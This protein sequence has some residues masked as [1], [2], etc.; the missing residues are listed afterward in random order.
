MLSKTELFYLPAVLIIFI[1]LN[2]LFYIIPILRNLINNYPYS[3]SAPTERTIDSDLI[4]CCFTQPTLAKC[5]DLTC[6]SLESSIS[7]RC[8]TVLHFFLQQCFSFISLAEEFKMKTDSA[9][10]RPSVTF[11]KQPDFH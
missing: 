7:K 9:G 1:N 3:I 11:S 8:H 4:V 6:S 5:I 2:I 10:K